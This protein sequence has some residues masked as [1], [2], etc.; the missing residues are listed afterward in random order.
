MMGLILLSIASIIIGILMLKAR[1]VSAKGIG[2]V[3]IGAAV[4]ALLGAVASVMAVPVIFPVVGVIFT[5]AWQFYVGF[6][7]YRLGQEAS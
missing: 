2:Y 7:L 5:A 4:F 3:V 1:E 6:K